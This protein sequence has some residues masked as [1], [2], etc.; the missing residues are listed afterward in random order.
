MELHEDQ[1]NVFNKLLEF[2]KSDKK[3]ILINSSAGTGKTFLITYFIQYIVKN[4][5]L[6]NLISVSTPTHT[7]LQELKS[8]LFKDDIDF[9]KTKIN[10]TTIHR[11]LEYKQQITKDNEKYFSRRSKSKLNWKKYNL[12]IIDECSMLNDDI[13]DDIFVQINKFSKTNNI[14]VIYIGDISQINPIKEDI[15]KIFIKDIDNLKLNKIIRTSDSKIMDICNAHK[16]WD[17]ENI[18]PNLADYKS[19]NIKYMDNKK[20]WLNKF[21]KVFKN[22]QNNIILCWTNEKKDYYNNY[23]RT[24]IFKKDNLEKYEIGEI[25]IFTDFHKIVE[26]INGEDKEIFFKSSEQFIILELN[27]NEYELEKMNIT[28]TKKLPQDINEI[29][30]TNLEKVNELLTKK[31]KVYNM[32]IKRNNIGVDNPDE[33][34]YNIK[35]IHNDGIIDLENIKHSGMDI[36]TEIKNIC[37]KSIS[38][39]KK[40]HSNIELC[41]YQ[42]EIEVKIIKIWNNWNNI[43]DVVAKVNYSYSITVHLSQSKTY[44][45]VF[46]DICNILS[47]SNTSEKKKLLYTALTRASN[48]L[49]LL[50]ED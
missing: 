48:S 29:I 14:K 21:I 46:I 4:N 40:K 44:N 30:I 9:D 16:K 47:N 32:K 15:S 22:S 49:N 34:I 8:K 26:N 36:I 37:Y 23:I 20:K 11:L 45:N 42:N 28:K 2:L 19:D 50:I 24:K 31:I 12:L 33:N 5:I 41:E 7:S 6:K 13:C 43:I 38:K 1:Q 18:V 35:V 25:L 10:L 17:L 39:N 27:V 3:E